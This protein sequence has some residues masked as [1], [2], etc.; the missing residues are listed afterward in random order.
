MLTDLY[1]K[2]LV[3]IHQLNI[4]LSKGLSSFSGETG[5]GKSILL[6]AL[7]LSLGK[8]GDVCLIRKGCDQTSISA[9]F[10]LP[11]HHPTLIMLK[12]LSLLNDDNPLEVVLRRTLNTKGVSKAFINDT[13]VNVATL[14]Q[15]GDQLLEIHGQ[16]D[17]LLDTKMHRKLL[18]QSIVDETFKHNITNLQSHYKAY[19]DLQEQ[20]DAVCQQEKSHL[21]QQFM[22]QTIIEE[23]SSLQ[24][25]ENE[26][27]EL[28][29]ERQNLDEL[30]K[31]GLLLQ[32]AY[33][34]SQDPTFT[35]ELRFLL[36]KIGTFTALN[37]LRTPLE[38][39]ESDLLEVFEISKEALHSTQEAQQRLEAIDDRLY[40]LRA[41]AKKF[42]IDTAQL[43]PLL[44]SAQQKNAMDYSLIK[45][46]ID[47]KIKRVQT[48]YL[49]TAKQLTKARQTI[50]KQLQEQIHNEFLNLKL[51]HA[52]FNVA[53]ETDEQM[54]TPYGIDRIEFMISTNKE[55]DLT[56]LTKTASGGEMARVMLALKCILS[57]KT[58]LVTL[59]FDEIE[60]GVGGAVASAIG[61]RMLKLSGSI[62][63]LSITHAPQIAACANHNYHV[64]KS[65]DQ[66][67]TQTSV[68]LLNFEEKILEVARMLSGESLTE[69]AIEA[70][71]DLCQ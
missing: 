21:Q 2:D 30:G 14:K 38:R 44:E 45:Q 71:K 33:Q 4:S 60:T 28:L 10:L 7:A 5:A 41:K 70:A 12:D 43:L 20:L 63:V 46:E 69:N 11:L 1:I 64:Q 18:D 51:P 39:I 3:L 19:K 9:V 58:D 48:D 40:V 13:P 55:Q 66:D 24:L 6:D 27:A 35:K 36:S 22:N 61:Q 67:A 59:V 57:Q 49:Q 31:S 29:T 68:R 8:R 53:I 50:A 52:R 42:G 17:H 26:E 15:V 56:P 34:L 32:K 54:M 25:L 47:H 62:Q 16:F 37:H 65:V 23:L